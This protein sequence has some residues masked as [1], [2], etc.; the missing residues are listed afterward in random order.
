MTIPKHVLE[1]WWANLKKFW[2][3]FNSNKTRP[4]APVTDELEFE[5]EK[6]KGFKGF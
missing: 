3:R 5:R 2:K 1:H 4:H 6:G